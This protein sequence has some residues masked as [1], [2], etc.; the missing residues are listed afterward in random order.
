MSNTWRR[1]IQTTTRGSFTVVIPKII[2]EKL[3]I[4]K[5]DVFVW[6]LHQGKITVEYEKSDKLKESKNQEL[7]DKIVQAMKVIREGK[8]IENTTT[9]PA[10]RS[11]ASRLEKLRIK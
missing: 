5:N 1:Y 10:K 2:I 9:T 6:R 7:S 4:E 8:E 3:D 11:K